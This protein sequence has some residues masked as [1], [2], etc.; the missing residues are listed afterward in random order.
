MFR[1]KGDPS[2]LSSEYSCMF[3]ATRSA[4]LQ[5]EEPGSRLWECQDPR[6]PT[7][8][9]AP[10]TAWVLRL[11]GVLSKEAPQLGA[12]GP[13]RVQA[14][15]G[16][17]GGS[18]PGSSVTMNLLLKSGDSCWRAQPMLIA[19]SLT[20]DA[21]PREGLRP[22]GPRKGLLIP[23]AVEPA[24]GWGRPTPRRGW[25]PPG[26]ATPEVNTGGNSNGPRPPPAKHQRSSAF[27]S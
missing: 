24:Q 4:P 23:L 6:V 11:Q 7:S 8:P 5:S 1:K 25:V 16:G 2:A 22:R 14:S 21:G 13:L 19:T 27:R 9:T 26:Q 10:H 17:G 3:R 15:V 18:Q 12:H 20:L